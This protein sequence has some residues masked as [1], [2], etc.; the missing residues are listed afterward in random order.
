MVLTDPACAQHRPTPGHPE[1]P[2]R[3]A[4]AIDGIA[5]AAREVAVIEDTPEPAPPERLARVHGADLLDTIAALAEAG[6]GRIDAD[7]EMS[8]GSASAMLLAAG[9]G[10]SAVDR[11]NRGDGDRAFCVVRPPGHH[12]TSMRSMGFCLVNHV[13]I[14]AAALVDRGER[15]AIV[16]IDVH[17]GNGTEDIFWSEPNVLFVSLH[18][19]P[20]YPGTGRV[21]DIG[22]GAGM[23]TTINVPLPAGTA[24]DGY[25]QAF[26]TVVVPAVE[27]FGPDWLLVSA[28]F[29]AHRDDPLASMG[30]SAGDY[31]DLGGR[32]TMLAPA[33][34]TIAWLEG[35]YDLDALRSSV[36]GFATAL[37]GAPVHPEPITTGP[38]HRDQVAE[39][40]AVHGLG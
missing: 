26:D 7:T 6:G 17:H 33:G 31:A 39:V 36:A 13:A 5:D 34:R 14:T 3:L 11:L 18:Q 15:V 10:L 12:A 1:R 30:L 8:A 19:S 28:G 25:R 35:G 24:G 23:G 20:L 22:G 21:G 29:D 16:D 38:V 37:G 4:A 32:L 2:E 9:A 27:R 40:V